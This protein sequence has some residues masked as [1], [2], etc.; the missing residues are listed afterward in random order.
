VA[1]ALPPR[2]WRRA[3]LERR[4]DGRW[5]RF[6]RPVR[7]RAAMRFRVRLARRARVRVVVESTHWRS[8]RSAPLRPRV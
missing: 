5:R 3:Y 6:T 7:P 1:L 8:L 4:M 2:G